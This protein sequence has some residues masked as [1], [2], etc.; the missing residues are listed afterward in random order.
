MEHFFFYAV[1]KR[2][3]KILLAKLLISL[4]NVLTLLVFDFVDYL[5]LNFALKLNTNIFP[6]ACLLV[7]LIQNVSFRRVD[8]LLKIYPQI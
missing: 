5:Q 8:I 1:I 3:R 4:G 7:C 6:F 2:W